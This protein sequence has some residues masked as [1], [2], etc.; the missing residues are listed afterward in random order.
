MGMYPFNPNKVLAKL[1]DENRENVVYDVHQQLLKKLTGMRY[2]AAATTSAQ[3]PKKKDKLPQGPFT[4][5]LLA[6]RLWL[7]LAV[8]VDDVDDP[9]VQVARSSRRT[10]I[11]PSGDSADETEDS[12]SSS[13]SEDSAVPNLSG[14][15]W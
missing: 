6:P 12:S 15:G 10:G 7:P 3:R 1:P 13:K 5:A 4:P 9:A 11:P 14:A 2:S 8:V